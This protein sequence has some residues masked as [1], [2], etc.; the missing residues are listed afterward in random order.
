MG[1]GVQTHGPPHLRPATPLHD[2]QMGEIYP[3]MFN[4]LNCTF[5]VSFFHVSIAVAIM[6]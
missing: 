4:E 5:G 6:V 1:G 2:D 3:T